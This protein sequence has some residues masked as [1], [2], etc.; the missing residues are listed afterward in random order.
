MPTDR[1]LIDALCRMQIGWSGECGCK[2]HLEL[3]AAVELV[4]NYGYEVSER[5]EYE[6]LKEKFE[7]L[8][9]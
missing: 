4:Q 9:E 2:D 6:R 1:E 8:K 7:P 5:A 3:K